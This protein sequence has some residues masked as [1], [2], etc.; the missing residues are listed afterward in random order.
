ME[1]MPPEI[2][3]A[4]KTDGP[5][6][7]PPGGA[8]RACAFKEIEPGKANQ[9][10][11]LLTEYEKASDARKAEIS[12]EILSRI[13]EPDQG[14]RAANVKEL[15]S[16]QDP[17]AWEF[18]KTLA[19]GPFG[20]LLMWQSEKVKNRE[21]ATEIEAFQSGQ[22]IKEPDE[23]RQ[24]FIEFRDANSQNAK[25]EGQMQHASQPVP[26]SKLEGGGIG[27][28]SE[29]RQASVNPGFQAGQ[30]EGFL[31]HHL[32]ASLGRGEEGRRMLPK[33][34]EAQIA[35]PAGGTDPG[36][37]AP[38]E[39][40]NELDGILLK[41]EF[42]RWM[43]R[44]AGTQ[45][46]LE[47]DRML[48]V[49]FAKSYYW[50]EEQRKKEREMLKALGAKASAD[51]RRRLQALEEEISKKHSLLDALKAKNLERALSD[52]ECSAAS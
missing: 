22:L 5:A 26:Q 16:T 45:S 36:R 8:A 13:N 3:E 37:L 41:R 52:L 2:V 33:G 12:A 9:F 38:G 10:K 34:Y 31:R 40:E 35:M 7:A 49:P 50:A 23:I 6:K 30:D 25:L 43:A 17:L 47:P 4:R 11:G 19:G 27:T 42:H 51:D 15:A 1:R 32:F 14:I 39:E 21:N 28:A 46:G 18:M 48:W 44:I 24:K 20:H 29:V